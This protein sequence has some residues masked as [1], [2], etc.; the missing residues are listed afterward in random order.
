M[1]CC[2]QKDTHTCDTIRVEKKVAPWGLPSLAVLK[3]VRTIW[4]RMDWAGWWWHLSNNPCHLTCHQANLCIWRHGHS[5]PSSPAELA[6]RRRTTKLTH[7][8]I[9][10]NSCCFKTHSFW[11]IVWC[12]PKLTDTHIRTILRSV[13]E[14]YRKQKACGAGFGVER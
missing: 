4:S 1:Y 10:S 6:Q 9:R 5:G 14:L 8:I 11:G 12:A 2:W 13:V 3:I 7:R